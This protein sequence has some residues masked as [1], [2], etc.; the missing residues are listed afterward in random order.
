MRRFQELNIL[1]SLAANTAFIALMA[2]DL[3]INKASNINWAR[4]QI[5]YMLG[6]NPRQ[7]SYVV[8][9]GQNPPKRPHH[10]SRYSF[11]VDELP[12]SPKHMRDDKMAQFTTLEKSD[13][14]Q[15]KFVLSD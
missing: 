15:G 14:Q 3:G 2:A 6:D 9:F 1:F 5:H 10:K 8:G 11:I 7:S 12:T 13:S 4:G